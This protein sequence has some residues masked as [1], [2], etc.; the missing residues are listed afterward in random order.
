MKKALL[1]ISILCL[2][3]SM[4]AQNALEN[5]SWNIGPDS[6]HF[7]TDSFS[8]TSFGT[9]LVKGIYTDTVNILRL[10]DYSGPEA[11]DSMLVGSYEMLFSNRKDTLYLSKITDNC[12]S[13]SV[14]LDGAVLTRKDL[15]ISINSQ[16]EEVLFE[17]YPN[18][19][20]DF[21]RFRRDESNHVSVYIINEN[22]QL[23][24]SRQLLSKSG[25]IDTRMLSKGAYLMTVKGEGIEQSHL[26]IK[27]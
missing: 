23:M 24:I 19:F 17:I 10:D 18:P 8:L 3:F 2:H 26:I 12:A 11:C 25:H 27:R 9:L 22:G 6:I 14:A 1:L 15:Y 21:I 16:I 20:A 7:H 5:T 13:R 4:K